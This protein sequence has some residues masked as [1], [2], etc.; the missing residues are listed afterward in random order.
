[1]RRSVDLRVSMSVV[2]AAVMGILAAFRAASMG[3][4]ATRGE[5]M[6]FLVLAVLMLLTA[7]FGAVY[8]WPGRGAPR[9]RFVDRA[10]YVGTEIRAR[11]IVFALLVLMVTCAG[12]L[13]LGAGVEI[14]LGNDG[15]PW[16]GVILLLVAVPCPVFLAEVALG[17]VRSTS[18]VLAPD[19]IRSRGWSAESYLP[20]I[21]VRR[22]R[23]V[24]HGFPEV[25]VEGD[26]GA[27]W[28]R[29]RTSRL[30][31]F[32]RIPGSPRIEVDARRFAVDPELLHRFLTLYAEQPQLRRELGTPAAAERLR[33]GSLQVVRSR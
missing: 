12:F 10:G 24:H 26:E 14:V 4:G 30:F 8:W 32:D 25:L 5:A 6:F 23:M 13:S 22:V 19:G 17:H 18:L 11:G 33:S 1:M 7:A 27:A 2:C 3:P 31:S 9:V 20:W 28:A 15:L 16:V 29:R 21:S